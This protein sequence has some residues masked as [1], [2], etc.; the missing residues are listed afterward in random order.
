[1]FLRG[2]SAVDGLNYLGYKLTL[3]KPNTHVYKVYASGYVLQF[4]KF[5]FPGKPS[6]RF[7]SA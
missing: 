4:S 1:M 2:P 7:L 6:D 5:T 3:I